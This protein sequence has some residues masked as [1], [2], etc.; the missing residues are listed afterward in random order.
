MRKIL[1]DRCHGEIE[2]DGEIVS[3]SIHVG[4]GIDKYVAYGTQLEDKSGMELCESCARHVMREIE[5]CPTE[6]A[7]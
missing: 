1:C 7:S 3:V 6:A 5:K 4:R 2:S